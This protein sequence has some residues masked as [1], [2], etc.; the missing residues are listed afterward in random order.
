MVDFTID[1]SFL[2]DL[3]KEEIEG[4]KI[5]KYIVR[6]GKNLMQKKM[7]QGAKA[8]IKFEGRTKDGELLDLKRDRNSER[9]LRVMIPDEL[10]WGFHVAVMSMKENEIS[11]FRFPP[12][13]HFYK[14]GNKTIPFPKNEGS[15]KNS[16]TIA[17]NDPLFY[18]ITLLE[19][20]NPE[21]IPAKM[22]YDG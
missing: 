13:Y 12:E 3:K 5:M 7:E 14:Y 8:R 20:N 6:E 22:D 15:E 17:R 18:K 4:G 21:K 2:E 10:I 16:E 19:F 9:V 1:M 11:W